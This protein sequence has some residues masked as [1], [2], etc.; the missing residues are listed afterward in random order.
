MVTADL[1]AGQ[2]SIQKMF[3]DLV[4]NTRRPAW[5]REES[6]QRR[7]GCVFVVEVKGM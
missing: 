5:S 3:C 1:D 4:L 6:V 2:K 7:A